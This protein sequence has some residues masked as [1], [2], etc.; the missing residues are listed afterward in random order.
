MTRRGGEID[1]WASQ[2]SLRRKADGY[3]ER[4]AAV[5]MVD[6]MPG[7][8][9]ITLGAD[10]QSAGAANLIEAVFSHTTSSATSRPELGVPPPFP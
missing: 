2:K 7:K 6:E 3:A 5:A 1:A 8:R 4:A 10:T 9:R